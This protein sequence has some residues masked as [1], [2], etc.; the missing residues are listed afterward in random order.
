MDCVVFLLRDM[1]GGSQSMSKTNS[2]ERN[3]QFLIVSLN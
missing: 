3:R 1:N 2:K